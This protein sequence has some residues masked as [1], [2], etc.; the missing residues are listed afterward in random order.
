M[1]SL[2]PL[3]PVSVLQL[4]DWLFRSVVIAVVIVT[5]GVVSL[6]QAP[7]RGRPL[8]VMT[9]NL[10]Q[11]TDFQE[12]IAAATASPASLPGFLSSVCTTMDN[13]RA[14][15]P[16]ERIAAVAQEIADNSPDLV[17][18]Q[19]A[20]LW[21]VAPG[22]PFADPRT[23]SFTTEVDPVGI[24]LANLQ[25]LGEPY[26]LEVVQP[27]FD[28][29]APC[30]TGYWVHTT[31]QVAILARV[32]SLR[33]QLKV[34]N[35]AGGVFDLENHTLTFP[36]DILGSVPIVRG[37][38]YADVEY[39]G[40]PVRFVTA[41]PEAF[42]DYYENQQVSELVGGVAN[43][44]NAGKPVIMAADFNTDPA[45]P[46]SSFRVGYEL[47]QQAGFADVWATTERKPALTC[48]YDDLKAPDFKLYEEIDYVFVQGFAGV[49]LVPENAKLTGNK[50]GSRVD[51]LWPSDH[52]G[53]I[54][55]IRV[56]E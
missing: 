9:R 46:N 40:T 2:L 12:A 39:R 28:F 11:G 48:C 38:A 41:H 49:N 22:S 26:Q 8:K 19:E 37:W 13:V 5:C 6:A 42:F 10:Y 17:A 51:G 3:R 1:N 14:T 50:P 32:D 25:S 23:L 21:Q 30:L 47:I 16:A 4:R 31:T 18:V 52:A 29:A 33:S 15:K 54:A 53:L 35:T 20:T 27:Q 56:G 36:S 34:T 43:P 44:V 24:L 55:R 45:S 7:D